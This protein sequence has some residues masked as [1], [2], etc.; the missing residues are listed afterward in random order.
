MQKLLFFVASSFR[1]QRDQGH[2]STVQRH[3]EVFVSGFV[4]VAQRLVGG[5]EV[6]VAA[7][8]LL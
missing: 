1:R 5:D 7:G 8:D 3:R 2:A 4:S 6:V